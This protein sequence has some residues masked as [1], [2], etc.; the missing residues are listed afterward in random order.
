MSH[1]IEIL[2]DKITHIHIKD[3]NINNE[4]V[5]LGTGLVNFSDVFCSLAKIQY[6]KSYVFETTRGSDPV[7]TAIYNMQVVDFFIENSKKNV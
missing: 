2:G 4:N 1:D 3:K 5:I 6:N 7:K